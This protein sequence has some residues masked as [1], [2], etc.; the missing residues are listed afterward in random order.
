M[1]KAKVETPPLVG[2]F[3]QLRTCANRTRTASPWRS[4]RREELSR[5]YELR[6]TNYFYIYNEIA[7]ASWERELLK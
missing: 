4:L 2:G 6:I 7:L 1:K 5:Y 3:I